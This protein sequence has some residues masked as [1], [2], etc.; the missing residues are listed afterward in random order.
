[1]LNFVFS[2]DRLGADKPPIQAAH[3]A[4]LH[5]DLSHRDPQIDL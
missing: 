3:D 4:G 1:M 2:C 5:A